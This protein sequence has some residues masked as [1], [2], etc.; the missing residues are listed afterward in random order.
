MFQRGG[1]VFQ[2]EKGRAVFINIIVLGSMFSVTPS[3]FYMLDF[4]ER[5][6]DFTGVY[7]CMCVQIVVGCVCIDECVCV[8]LY[9]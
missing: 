6:S 3:T 9:H 1:E 5:L 2:Q 4:T 7:V 8:L